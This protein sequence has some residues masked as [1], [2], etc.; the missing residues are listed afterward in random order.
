MIA[1]VINGCSG[2]MSSSLAKLFKDNASIHYLGSLACRSPGADLKVPSYVKIIKIGDF[3]ERTP[4]IVDFTN[5][6]STSKLLNLA[7]DLPCKLIIGTSGLNDSDKKL[8]IKV[9]RKRAVFYSANFSLGVYAVLKALMQMRKTLG[10]SW[11]AHVLDFHFAEKLDI[12]SAT[13]KEFSRAVT[14]S[15]S[16]AVEI[17]A[18]RLGDGVS[19][20]TAIISGSGE[21]IEIAHKLLDRKAFAPTVEDAVYFLEDKKNGI[22]G[23][24]DLYAA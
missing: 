8:L 20:H 18:L 24:D 22:Y 13:A 19:E 14:V 16:K 21:R 12:P 10:E 2:K 6:E 23:M 5:R 17:S 3:R 1:V 7:I 11:A 4:I 15:G 9:A